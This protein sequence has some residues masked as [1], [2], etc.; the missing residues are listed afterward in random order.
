[1]RTGV[2]VAVSVAVAAV[3][4]TVAFVLLGDD[5]PGP[6]GAAGD[7]LAA[8]SAGDLEAMAA[9]VDGPPPSFDD[10]HTAVTQDLRI[11]AA[12]FALGQVTT[13]GDE[14]RA[15]FTATLTIA[16]LGDWSYDSVLPLRLAGDDQGWLVAWS[17]AV[18]H[19][20]LADGL[21]LGRERN[22]P[23]RAPI[24]DRNGEPLAAERPAV[25]IGVEPQ[26]MNDETEVTAALVEHLGVDPV[27]VERALAAP[28]VRPDHFVPIVTVH[29]ARYEEVR[30]AIYPVPGILFRETEA[31]LAPSDGF[32]QHVLGRTGEITAEGLEQLGATY[33]VGD[34]VGAT[35]L[36]ARFE[37]ELAGVPSGRIVLLDTVA[38]DA[39]IDVLHEFPG[40]AG[41]PVATTI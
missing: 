18:V 22:R 11:R 20:R 12:S 21:R 1:M 34:V 41:A 19:P 3:V 39:V 9:L 8:W 26:R 4:A 33:Q 31:R 16:G 6:E 29:R 27:A 36:E 13:E 37:R 35:G 2:L 15:A 10:A 7:Y 5:G 17:P 25:T 38:D 24:L 28:G 40:T 30:P 32:A 23:E 14:A